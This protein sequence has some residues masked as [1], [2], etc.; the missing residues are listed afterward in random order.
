MS[1]TINFFNI[2]TIPCPSSLIYSIPLENDNSQIIPK[3]YTIFDNYCLSG[4][5][6]STE[7]IPIKLVTN[8]NTNQ[9]GICTNLTCILTNL[10]NDVEENDDENSNVTK[11]NKSISEFSKITLLTFAIL[12]SLLSIY[13]LYKIIIKKYEKYQLK[14]GRKIRTLHDMTIRD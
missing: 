8:I 1:K 12:L 6:N 9:I 3:N 10:E 13:I 2:T 11:P 4:N 5:I 7:F 14:T